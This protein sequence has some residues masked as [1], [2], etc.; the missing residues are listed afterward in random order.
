MN[1][2]TSRGIIKDPELFSGRAEQLQTIKNLLLTMQSCSVVGPRRIG[3]SSLLFYLSRPSYHAKEYPPEYK[4]IFLDLQEL[5][6][7][8]VEDFF[9]TVFSRLRRVY[10]DLAPVDANIDAS[11]SGFRR[12]LAEISDAGTKLILCLDEFEMLSQN[13]NF[14]ADFFTLL[15]G[16]CSN[17]NFVLVTS[18]RKSLF[19]LCHQRDLQTSQLWNIFVELPLGPMKPDEIQTLIRQY[20]KRGNLSIHQE[21]IDRTLALAGCHPFFVQIALYFLFEACLNQQTPDFTTIR[22]LFMNEST[23]HYTYAW[24]QLEKQYQGILLQLEHNPTSITNPVF[25]ILRREALL[26]GSA[27]NPEFT[28]D[29]FREFVRTQSIKSPNPPL[30]PDSES[31]SEA[32]PPGTIQQ[33]AQAKSCNIFVS[34]RRSD[35]ADITGRIYDRLIGRFGKEPIFKDVDSIPLGL[36]FMEYLDM[37]V[38]EC[39]VLL[40]IIGDHWLDAKDDK[41]NNRLDDPADFVRIEVQA[42]LDRN[43]PVIPLLVRDARMPREEDLPPKLRK[44]VY[45]NGTPVRPDPD[46]HRDMDRLIAALEKLVK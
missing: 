14:S 29:G 25:Q 28:S 36:D 26:Q 44:L 7:A 42:A 8:K 20:L 33:E 38:G 32:V 11:M 40:A 6:G 21:Y 45:R 2:F 43:I 1:P 19:D 35:S 3:K 27:E 16:L 31:K 22:D 41:G 10:P 17:Y 30:T 12:L 18:S 24:D 4:F 5:S 39:D 37:K 23:R 9:V 46:F 15:R 13:S 34:Y